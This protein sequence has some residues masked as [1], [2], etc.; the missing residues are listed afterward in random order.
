MYLHPPIEWTKQEIIQELF[1]WE[2]IVLGLP[3]I[4]HSRYQVLQESTSELDTTY[5]SVLTKLPDE[6]DWLGSAHDA[7]DKLIFQVNDY[8]NV[9]IIDM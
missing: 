2:Q 1:S 6:R 8:V 5:K 9:S 4:Q 7:V 3:R